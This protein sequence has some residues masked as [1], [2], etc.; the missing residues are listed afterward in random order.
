MPAPESAATNRDEYP[1]P[2]DA[3][4][5]GENWPQA[6]K[7]RAAMLARL[8]AGVGRL[9]EQLQQSGMTNNVAIFLTGA[10]APPPFADTNL[11]F[12]KVPGEECA[13]ENQ[14]TGCRVP[15]V[16][17]WPGHIQSLARVSAEQ[18]SAAW[19][20]RP[21]RCRLVT[22]NWGR[23]LQA[24]PFCRN[25]SAGRPPMRRPGR[26][27]PTTHDVAG[28]QLAHD[29]FLLGRIASQRPVPIALAFNRFHSDAHPDDGQHEAQRQTGGN[30]PGPFVAARLLARFV[31]LR[32][33]ILPICTRR[34]QERPDFG[35]AGCAPASFRQKKD[36]FRGMSY[37]NHSFVRDFGF[38]RLCL[39]AWLLQFTFP[40]Y[41]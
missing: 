35:P 25:C 17:R 8:D 30:Q 27:G 32:R 14:K 40:D 33:I 12:L 1:V 26:T 16:V 7:N 22:G 31:H 19:T 41:L 23:I 24:G 36:N 5:T 38:L 39:A 10:V 6:A 20:L 2:T 28:P 29:Q 11:N 18:Q 21:R 4:F 9:L 34:E 15:M 13:A 37:K 3:P